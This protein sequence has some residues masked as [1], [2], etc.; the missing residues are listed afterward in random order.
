[1]EPQVPFDGT[2][3]VPTTMLTRVI[4]VGGSLLDWPPLPTA[5]RHWLDA[6][7]AAFNVLLC[8]GGDLADAIR[9]ADR[10]FALGEQFSHWLCIDAMSITA[11]LLAAI[12]K[13]P[14]LTEYNELLA[15]L[16]R[17]EPGHVVLD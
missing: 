6:Q 13:M 8:G 15:R 4:K 12:G 17:R 1:M 5:L 11:R 2:R 16:A 10:D 9:Q 3:S 7:P 14:L